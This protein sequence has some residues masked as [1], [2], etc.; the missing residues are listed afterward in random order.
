MTADKYTV[1]IAISKYEFKSK[2]DI[3]YKNLTESSQ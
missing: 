2:D 3:F 1:S